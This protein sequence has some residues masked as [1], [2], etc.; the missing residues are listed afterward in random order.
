MFRLADIQIVKPG[1]MPVVIGKLVYPI[2]CS[3]LPEATFRSWK[4]D[5]NRQCSCQRDCGC[6]RHCACNPQCGKHCRCVGQ[7]S[8]EFY[9]PPCGCQNVNYGCVAAETLVLV[10]GGVGKPISEFRVGDPILSRD[11][12]TGQN[13]EA[14]VLTVEG[15]TE[16]NNTYFVQ[17]QGAGTIICSLDQHFLSGQWWV[18]TKELKVGDQVN[19]LV[20]EKAGPKGSLHIVYDLRVTPYGNYIVLTTT[21]AQLV[22][23]DYRSLEEDLHPIV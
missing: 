18:T 8:C 13:V 15:P 5:C 12:K 17:F 22:A 6:H 16:V 4:C 23:H 11:Y 1:E 9:S 19:G 3:Q 2:S 7:C 14:Q 10:P 21:G 20:V